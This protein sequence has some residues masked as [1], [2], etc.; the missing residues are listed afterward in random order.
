M[1]RQRALNMKVY[2]LL[3]LIMLAGSFG[4]GFDQ[5]KSAQAQIAYK[6]VGYLPS[7]Q[8][9]VNGAQIDKLT[10]VNYAFLLPNND[11]SLKP[12]ENSSK[13]QELVSVAHSKNKKVLISVGGWNDGDDSAFESI[14]ANASYR[15]NFANNLNNFVNQYNLDGVDID[16]EYPEAG[17]FYFETMSAIR[18][19]IGSGKLLTAAVAATNAGGSGVTSNAI[20]IMDYITLMAYD[21]DGG[22]GHSPY[23]LAQQSLDYWSTKTSDKAKLILGVPFYARPGWYGYNTL[24]AGGC[25]ADSDSCWYGGATQYYTGRPTMRSKIDLMKSKGGGGIMIWELSQDTAI[26]S[27]ESLLKTIA[28]QLGTPSTPTGNVALNKAATAS[29]TENSSY[30]ANFAFD[31]NSTTRWS[32]T[33]SDPQWLR[34]DLGAVYAI[35]QV[36]LKWEAAF[37]RAYQVQVSNDDNTWRSISS[38][39]NSDGAT[40]DLAVSG[41]GRYLRVYATTRATE[42]GYSLWE[43]EV[44]GNA[45]ATSASSTE[46]GGSTTNAIDTNSATRWSAG[47]PQAAGQWYRVDFGNSQSFSQIT[48]DAGTS[49]GDY[50]RNFQ[51]QV[52]NDGNSWATIATASGTT[53][54]VTVNF[55]AQNSRYLRVWLTSTGGGSWWSIHELTVR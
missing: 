50:P 14:A 38:T 1:N 37:G 26:T 4:A 27:S 39:S 33:W 34:V 46:T 32:S 40:D 5:P 43:V 52:S 35:K 45:L 41:V 7:W 15:T 23:S 8:G 13:L 20:E 44:Y 36:V 42:W 25:S 3:A 51:V 30:G 16:W 10:H 18:N 2:L 12:I 55:A 17:D 11:G 21:G 6:I 24:R 22:A 54:A 31:G 49:Y 28:D 48:L 29:S 53:Q 9:S 19:R 47:L